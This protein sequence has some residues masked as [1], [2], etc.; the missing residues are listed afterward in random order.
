MRKKFYEIINGWRSSGPMKRNK[1]PKSNP[2][3]KNHFALRFSNVTVVIVVT[4]FL[5]KCADDKVIV[6]FTEPERDYAELTIQFG[7]ALTKGNGIPDLTEYK[8]GTSAIKYNKGISTIKTDKDCISAANINADNGEMPSTKADDEEIPATDDEKKIESLACFVQTFDEGIIGQEGYK[9][10]TFLKFFTHEAKGTTNGF[11][12]YDFDNAPP[13]VKLKIQS[14]GFKGETQLVFIANYEQ[15]GLKDALVNITRM[16]DLATVHTSEVTTQ[17]IKYPLLMTGT[18]EVP[19]SN[20]SI[21]TGQEVTLTRIMARIDI[22]NNA[23]TGE[24]PFV[25]QS[26]EI[27]N[28]KLYSYV[29]EGNDD[30]YNIPVITDGFTAVQ[31]GNSDI[32]EGLYTY[33]T[34]NDGSVEHTAVLIRGTLNGEPYIKRIE[35]QAAGQPVPLGRNRRYLVTLNKTGSSQ[36]ISFTFKI[37]DWE[38]GSTFPIQP[39]HNKPVFEELEFSNGFNRN[40]WNEAEALYNIENQPTGRITFTV[41]GRQQIAVKVSETKSYAEGSTSNLE[42]LVNIQVSDPVINENGTM[43]QYVTLDFATSGILQNKEPVDLSIQ[44]Y[45]AAKPSY[46]QTIHITNLLPYPGTNFKP[47]WFGGLY[48]APVNVGA[49]QLEADIV[50]GQPVRTNAHMGYYFQWGR[51]VPFYLLPGIPAERRVQGPLSYQEANNAINKDKHINSTTNDWILAEDVDRPIRDG[52]WG[53]GN[54]NDNPC[55]AGWRLPT[56]QEGLSLKNTFDFN[57]MIDRSKKRFTYKGD[58][59]QPLYFPFVSHSIYTANGD[60]QPEQERI[61][62]W[63]SEVAQPYIGTAHVMD[64]MRVEWV[65][66]AIAYAF[67]VRCVRK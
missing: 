9:P 50:N 5:T 49:T 29:I 1:V 25:L 10:G 21:V 65:A 31:A 2:G 43:T 30:S 6:P 7:K 34:A 22:K 17:G 64:I 36:E 67:T 28:P 15:N 37:D 48:W 51:N 39:E 20:N 52:L 13:T 63:T 66:H 58:D 3:N 53:N 33:E 45:N 4:L 24:N 40:Y 26:A 44:V 12:D 54:D 59:G 57:N 11:T 46:N 41:T 38:D 18:L 56:F 47:V 62:F 35:M 42:S 61:L 19:L 27:I 16:E 23:N 60:I 14:Q 32:I 55:P 8:D